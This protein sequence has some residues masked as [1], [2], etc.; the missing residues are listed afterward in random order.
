M[1]SQTTNVSTTLKDY[2]ETQNP[3]KLMLHLGCGGV[4]WKDF[5]NIDLHPAMSNE[6]DSSR[7]GCVADY[8]ADMRDLQLPDESIDD[9]FTSHTIDHFPRW[10]GISML[11]DWHRMLKPNGRCIIEA[12]D[13]WKC[14][15][16]LFHPSKK[17]RHLA[18][19]QFYGNQWDEIDFETHR[20][21]WSSRE[22]KSVLVEEAGFRSVA[23][24][25]R[26]STHVAGR[27]MRVTAVK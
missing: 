24:T 17:C 4:K 10:T 7:D 11:K 20:Y 13:F 27:D 18:R 9:I 6:K 2:Y 22:L 3:Q 8:F 25:H 15:F 23:V 14:V 1:N 19:T 21:V 26:V 12:A 5:L 16:W